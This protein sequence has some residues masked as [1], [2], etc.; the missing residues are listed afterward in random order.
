[1]IWEK[2][3]RRGTGICLRTNRTCSRW[4]PICDCSRRYISQLYLFSY[5]F[6]F[7]G[8]GE[9]RILIF[10]VQNTILLYKLGHFMLNNVEVGVLALRTLAVSLAPCSFLPS[11][12]SLSRKVLKQRW[13]WISFAIVWEQ[14][15]SRLNVGARKNCNV[16]PTIVH[17]LNELQ[18]WV[19]IQEFKN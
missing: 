3:R 2:W 9:W 5:L 1:M 18:L 7:S 10:C 15:L 16:G 13:C 6:R 14:F 17:E 4:L 8:W 19:S 11:N 12:C